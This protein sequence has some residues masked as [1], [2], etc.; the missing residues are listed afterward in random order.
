MIENKKKPGSAKEKGFN[1]RSVKVINNNNPIITIYKTVTSQDPFNITL[2]K[3]IQRIKNGNSRSLILK[4]RNIKSKNDK[5]SI[6]I[7]LPAVAFTGLFK[8]R[9]EILTPSKLAILDFDCVKDISKLQNILKKSIYIYSSWISPSGDG[10][11][12]LVKIPYVNNRIEYTEY[13]K[14]LLDY[15]KELKPDISTKDRNRLTYESYDPNIYINDLSQEFNNKIEYKE[16]PQ[17]KSITSTDLQDDEIIDRILKWWLKKF[18]PIKGNRN[19]NLF[20]LAC[21]LS[22]YGI[23]KSITEN[24]LSSLIESDFAISEINGLINSAYK[25]TVFNSKYF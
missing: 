12:A 9:T 13:Y 5:K 23:L 21:S 1:K 10:I 14:A 7:L 8:S 22:E 19:H 15:F 16:N 6:K 2:K 20:I 11:K 3:A 18:E 4:L 24:L 17:I 25:K